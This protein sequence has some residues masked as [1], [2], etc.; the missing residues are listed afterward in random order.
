[1][2]SHTSSIRTLLMRDGRALH[3]GHFD[4]LGKKSLHQFAHDLWSVDLTD[5]FRLV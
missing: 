3:H 4:D 1:M 2:C 5:E